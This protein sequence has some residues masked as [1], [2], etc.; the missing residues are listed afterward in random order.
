[1]DGAGQ[2]DQGQTICLRVDLRRRDALLIGRQR[3][4]DVLRR[5]GNRAERPPSPIEPG[6]PGGGGLQAGP[7]EQ[8]TRDR[9]AGVRSEETNAGA[10]GERV[11]HQALVV[12]IETLGKHGP[13]LA[14]QQV[15]ARGD[16]GVRGLGQQPRD[17]RGVQ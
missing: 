3:D 7:D 15:A 14:I 10:Q 13:L 9:K 17:R 4:P 6:Q 12:D 8:V 1:M 11:S 5:L 2:I 16:H